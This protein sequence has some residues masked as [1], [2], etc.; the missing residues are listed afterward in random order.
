MFTVAGSSERALRT[1]RDS[2][3]RSIAAPTSASGS[4]RLGGGP[5]AGGGG[6]MTLGGAF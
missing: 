5:V 4:L 2:S 3:G 1:Y 6:V